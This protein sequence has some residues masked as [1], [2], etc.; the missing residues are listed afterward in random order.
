[1][2]KFCFL[3]KTIG[4][5]FPGFSLAVIRTIKGS[6]M[7]QIWYASNLRVAMCSSCKVKGNHIITL[8]ISSE[9]KKK[10]KKQEREKIGKIKIGHGDIITLF[11]FFFPFKNCSLNETKHIE[12]KIHTKARMKK[13]NKRGNKNYY[14]FS[15]F[16]YNCIM[17]KKLIFQW[18]HISQTIN[19]DKQ[20]SRHF[21]TIC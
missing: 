15:N 9:T 5:T 13:V 6:T 4:I 11:W 16:Y 7:A 18:L 10:R 21:C 2:C 12:L 14:R 17:K 20:M 1:M 8:R 3:F 19:C